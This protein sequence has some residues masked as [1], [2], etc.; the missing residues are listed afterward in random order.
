MCPSCALIS[1]AYAR[2][3]L[4]LADFE[5]ALQFDAE[6][7][8]DQITPE[9][10]QL[11]QRLEPFG[12][13]NPEPVF[14]ANNVRLLAPARVMKEK[15]IKLKLAE[16]R[17]PGTANGHSHRAWNALGWRMAERWAQ[18]Q[19]LPGDVLDIA[20]TLDHNDHPD[21]GGLELSLKDFKSQKT[22]TQNRDRRETSNHAV[23]LGTAGA[24][25]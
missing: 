9:L 2:A 5:P 7:P 4:T 3:C 23:N 8:L 22:T 15:H 20:F 18:A 24:P 12:S 11:L 14:V 6:L 21:F 16:S 1:I 25:S 19:L 13:R 17:E 10:F